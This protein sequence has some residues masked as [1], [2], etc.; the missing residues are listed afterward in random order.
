MLPIA[1]IVVVFEYTSTYTT[2]VIVTI[3]IITNHELR[4]ALH[5][6]YFMLRTVCLEV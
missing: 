4:D 5:V 2:Y 6:S 1:S 3:V